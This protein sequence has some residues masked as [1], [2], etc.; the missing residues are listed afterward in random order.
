MPHTGQAASY[1]AYGSSLCPAHSNTSTWAREPRRRLFQRCCRSSVGC[2]RA[3]QPP[4]ALHNQTTVQLCCTCAPKV[5]PLSSSYVHHMHMRMRVHQAHTCR[6]THAGQRCA[7]ISRPVCAHAPPTSKPPHSL[8]THPRATKPH[9][10]QDTTTRQ[11]VC[12]ACHTSPAHEEGSVMR[13][14]HKRSRQPALATR[15][16]PALPAHG[17]TPTGTARR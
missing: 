16:P 12:A 11:Q 10:Q 15:L 2:C 6:D 1:R 17:T 9:A 7:R 8:H 13:T 14:Q 5:T 3:A 4:G